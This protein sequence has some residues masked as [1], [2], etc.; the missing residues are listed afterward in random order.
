MILENYLKTTP[1]VCI[2]ELPEMRLSPW[3]RNTTKNLFTYSMPKQL[4]P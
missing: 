4:K 2:L 1:D 3:L